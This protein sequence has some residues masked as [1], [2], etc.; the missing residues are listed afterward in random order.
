MM[1]IRR[2]R[3]PIQMKTVDTLNNLGN[4]A[5][6][7]VGNGFDIECGLE[8]KYEHFLNFVDETCKSEIFKSALMSLSLSSA[9]L[10]R[11]FEDVVFSNIEEGDYK[12]ELHTSMRLIAYFGYATI[13]RNFW[14]QHFQSYKSGEKWVDF[15]SE[16]SRLIKQVED[17]MRRGNAQ[18]LSLDDYIPV[19]AV[20]DLNELAGAIGLTNA[21]VILGTTGTEN[22]G[23]LNVRYRSLR[24][25]LINDL[26]AMTRAFEGYLKYTIIP[27]EIV[28]TVAIDELINLLENRD[29]VRV[30]CFNYTDTFERLLRDRGVNAEFCY[31]HG[32]VGSDERHDRMVLGI[33]EHLAVEDIERFAG[34]AP[35]RKYHQR[36]YKE[37]DCVYK[38]WLDSITA[39]PN[40]P[41]DLFIFGHSLAPSDK[42]ILKPFI[43]AQ[44]MQTVV[45]YHDEGMHADIITNLAANLGVDYLTRNV[46][47]Q[48]HTLE[49]RRQLRQEDQ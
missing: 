41:R 42:E 30:L 34:F 26:Y 48:K 6:V 32:K 46:G 13:M 20:R 5:Y 40:M 23:Y 19:T 8:T 12:P 14:Y 29:C 43:T 49:F 10:S 36:I 1:L 35:F 2:G 39:R 25:R 15:E 47:G 18:S 9:D 11:L 37:T 44:G 27:K 28:S 3:V 17:S 31:V 7:I 33:D 38:D 22:A 4:E 16:L 45:F 21:Q 24:D